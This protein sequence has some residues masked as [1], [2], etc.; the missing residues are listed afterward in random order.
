MR[1]AVDFDG[2]IVEHKFPRLGEPVPLA[3]EWLRRY[4]A[5]GATL[6]LWTMRSDR[7]DEKYLTDAVEYCRKCDLEFDGV[8]EGVHDRDWT[9][10][11]KAYA[12]VYIDDAAFGC[13]LVR[14]DREDPRR[15][16]YVDWSVVGPAVEARILTGGAF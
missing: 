13:P 10:S 14:C 5:L 15:R 2:T 4:K 8:N 11:P 3:I 16:P 7:G 6:I 1:I 9:T 12:N